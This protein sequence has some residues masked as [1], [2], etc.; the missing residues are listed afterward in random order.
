MPVGGRRDHDVP[1][2]ISGEPDEALQDGGRAARGADRVAGD[3]GGLPK[4]AVGEEAAGGEVERLVVPDGERVQRVVSVLSHH[5][6]GPPALALVVAVLSRGGSQQAAQQDPAADE[7]QRNRSIDDEAGVG[8]SAG[9]DRARRKVAARRGDRAVQLGSF[10]GSDVGDR[11]E[12]VDAGARGEPQGVGEAGRAQGTDAPGERPQVAENQ[13]R[14]DEI[15]RRVYRAEAVREPGDADQAEGGDRDNRRPTLA[16][17]ET[18]CQQQKAEAAGDAQDVQRKIGEPGAR[19]ATGEHDAGELAQDR[20][21]PGDRRGRCRHP[22]S[23]A[24][25]SA[26]HLSAALMPEP[27]PRSSPIRPEG[28]SGR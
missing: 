2:A 13:K 5:R 24:A 15:D 11:V 28:K 7:G 21:H 16:V 6:R 8:R 27:S 10:A 4:H 20:R 14:R 26:I 3:D 9:D 23:P 25:E 17:P 18:G 19:V 1:A 12:G 22:A